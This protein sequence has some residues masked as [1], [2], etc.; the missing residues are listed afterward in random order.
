MNINLRIT[1]VFYM[2]SYLMICP[3]SF[4]ADDTDPPKPAKI[5][6]YPSEMKVK[7]TG[8]W[9]TVKKKKKK[10]GMYPV[11]L[12]YTG[13][14]GQE[15]TLDVEVAPRG[16]TRRMKVCKFPP[17]KIFFDKEK[18]KG[19]EFRGN[20]S[21]KLVTYC[22]L[23]SKYE[24]YYVKEFLTYRMYNLL[25][26][27]SFRVKPL[28]IEY[29]DSEKGGDSVTRFGFLIEDVDEVAKRNDVEKLTIPKVRKYRTLDPVTTSHFSL[30][31]FMIG[32][33][34]WSTTS[35]PKVDGCCHN[36]RL[37]GPGNEMTPKYGI[38]YDFDASGLV[39]THYAA[40]PE[41]LKVKNVRQ[42]LYRGFCAFN[43]HLPQSAS[44]L[45]E[46][47]AEMLAMFNNNTYLNS[48]SKKDSVKYLEGFYEILNDPKKFQ[49]SVTD[50]CRG[51]K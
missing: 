31:Q 43:D 23:N 50:K 32:N 46:K 20:G 5:F 4:A 41:G 47:R 29:I 2:V 17:L 48:K 12:T 27:Y 18:T 30:F 14:D 22:D 36:F 42:R 8:P 3:F 11:K 49:K 15:H 39:N 45:N 13:A 44:L 40:P 51:K 37:I 19:T 7:F 24:Q 26:E 34:D 21:L 6:N 38:P 25:T 33:L 28:S 10:D 35:G 9:N 1:A 16:I